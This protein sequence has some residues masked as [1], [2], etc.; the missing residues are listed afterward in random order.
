MSLNVLDEHEGPL[1]RSPLLNLHQSVV[2]LCH[3]IDVRATAVKHATTTTVHNNHPALQHRGP[4]ILR[5]ATYGCLSSKGERPL[6]NW[7]PEGGMR[8]LFN[9]S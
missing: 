4:S 2:W 5:T 3:A 8:W 1:I 9:E 6:V 7:G